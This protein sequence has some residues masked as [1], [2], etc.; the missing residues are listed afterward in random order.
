MAQDIRLPREERMRTYR[1][2]PYRHV[3]EHRSLENLPVGMVP[4]CVEFDETYEDLCDFVHPPDAIYVF[5]PEDGGVPKGIR[6]ACWRFV[7]IPTTTCLN[8]AAAVNVTL[9]DRLSKSKRRY[10]DADDTSRGAERAR[11]CEPAA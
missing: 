6:T 10:T 7:R 8:L 9:Y 11:R 3:A 2:V 5:G 4:V 1:D